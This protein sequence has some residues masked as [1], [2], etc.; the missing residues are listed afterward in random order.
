MQLFE[1]QVSSLTLSYIC[2]ASWEASGGLDERSSGAAQWLWLYH[3]AHTSPVS[4]PVSMFEGYC[5]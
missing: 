3:L 4:H 5:A 2:A 1:V